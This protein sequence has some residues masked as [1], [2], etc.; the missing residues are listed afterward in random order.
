MEDF[1]K[2]FPVTE[3]YTYLNTASCGLFSRSLVA[4]RHQHDLNLMEGGSIFRDKHKA[5]IREIRGRL[6]D[7]LSTPEDTIALVPNFSFGMNTIL[8]GLPKNKKILLLNGDYPSISWPV[9]TREFEVCYANIDENLEGNIEQAMAEHHPDIFAFSMVQYISGVLM[10]TEFLHRLKAYHPDLLLIADAT[11][12]LGTV[13]FNFTESPIDVMGASAYKWMLAGY[14]NGFFMIKPEVQSQ[15][16][17]RTIGYNSADFTFGNKDEIGLIGH[18]EP[19]HQD[20]LNYGSLGESVAFLQNIGMEEVEN[21][22]SSLKS[23][24]KKEFEKR[25]LLEKAVTVRENHSTIFNLKGDKELFEKLKENNIICSLRGDGIRVSF[26]LYN[27]I[28]DLNKL[29][30]VIDQ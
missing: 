24:A 5:H 20:T 19:G 18:M 29:L 14:G 11:Q 9:E 15:I 30:E 1:R 16:L 21:H 3:S 27:T 23:E 2:E 13:D 4:W 8:S 6:A 10:D 25:G 26:H 17:P 12:Y 22:L 28:D 7:F